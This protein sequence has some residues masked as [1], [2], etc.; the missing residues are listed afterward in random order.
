[1]TIPTQT[2]A[3][4]ASTLS[5]KDIPTIV[6]EATKQY[7]RDAIGCGIYGSQTSWVNSLNNPIPE[8]G[9]SPRRLSGCRGFT[10]EAIP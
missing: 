10:V 1:M 3:A 2:L 5:Y 9:G 6:R 4:L 7:V 8:Y